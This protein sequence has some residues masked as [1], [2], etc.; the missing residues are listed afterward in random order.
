MTWLNLGSFLYWCT[1]WTET[2]S[3]QAVILFHFAFSYAIIIVQVGPFFSSCWVYVHFKVMQMRQQVLGQPSSELCSIYV[4]V[5]QFSPSRNGW[6]IYESSAAYFILFAAPAQSH[7][8]LSLPSPLYSPS[9]QFEAAWALTNIASG[10][11]EQTQA[12]VQS[13]K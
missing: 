4:N 8:L 6:N 5:F 9:L 7:S 2:T 1:A 13:S 3:K 10:T 11:S 12:V